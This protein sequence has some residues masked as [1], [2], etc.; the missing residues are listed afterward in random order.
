MAYEIQALIARAEVLVP[1]SAHG[2]DL[3][4][5]TL[6]QRLVLVPMSDQLHDR[7]AIP[8]GDRLGFWRLPAGFAGV[9]VAWSATGPIAYVEA[10]FFGGVGEQR[11][12]VWDQGELVLGPLFCSEGES[13]PVAGTPISQALRRV[14]ATA[15]GQ[16]DEFAAVG[17]ARH[18][19]ME[20]WLGE[21]TTPF[22][23]DVG[24]NTGG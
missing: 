13:I 21:P 5:V 23:P 19:H 2:P 15:R 1:H 9:L 22:H 3:H 4:L 17:M 8:D 6:A 10:E 24:S 16:V 7:L 12:A 20:Q 11:A 14:G 18:R